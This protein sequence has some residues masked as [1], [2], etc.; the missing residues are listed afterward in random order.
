MVVIRLKPIGR[1]NQRHYRIVVVEKRSKLDGKYTE[2]LGFNN[3]F[4]KEVVINEERAKY[5]IGVGARA[6]DTVHNM[7]VT[8][9]II[10]GPKIPVHS[11]SKKKAEEVQATAPAAPAQEAPVVAE[12]P[13][14]PKEETA[15][16]PAPVETPAA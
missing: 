13:E 6:S 8:K 16:A 9:G 4:K 15:D 11:K 1:K 3:P 2:D 10:A 12:T 5:W 7:F 14:P